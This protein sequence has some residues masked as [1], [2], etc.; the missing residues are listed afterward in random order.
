[1]KISKLISS[2]LK[3]DKNNIDIIDED[4][5]KKTFEEREIHIKGKSSYEEYSLVDI[6]PNGTKFVVLEDWSENYENGDCSWYVMIMF[7]YHELYII[8]HDRG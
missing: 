7:K 8:L 2:Y 1:M 4:E 5:G 6:L 3:H